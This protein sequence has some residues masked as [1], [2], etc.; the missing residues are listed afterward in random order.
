MSPIVVAMLAASASTII[1]YVRNRPNNSSLPWLDSF[2]LHASLTWPVLFKT[3]LGVLLFS[4]ATPQP[5]TQLLIAY[6]PGILAGG[7]LLAFRL[8]RGARQ[9]SPAGC[10]IFIVTVLGVPFT[11]LADATPLVFLAAL[12]YLPFC[13]RS[14]YPVEATAWSNSARAALAISVSAFAFAAL[15]RP[16]IAMEAC[17]VDKCSIF[18]IVLTSPLTGNGNYFGVATVIFCS[19]AVVG[20]KPLASILTLSAA[21]LVIESAGSRSAMI[22]LVAVAAFALSRIVSLRAGYLLG[23]WIILPLG[24]VATVTTA[25]AELPADFATG[26][27]ALWSVA[28]KLIAES[29]IWGWGPSYWTRQ[30]VTSSFNANYGTHNIWLE[31]GVAGGLIAVFALAFAAIAVLRVTNTHTRVVVVSLFIALAYLS[32]LESAVQVSRLGLIPAAGL[33]PVAIAAGSLP[34]Q[35]S[36][37]RGIHTVKDVHQSQDHALSNDRGERKK[38]VP[39]VR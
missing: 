29:P 14:P 8:V 27:S 5:E 22:A 36:V 15:I 24:V 3:T 10:A 11:L 12:A 2:W 30:Q 21:A 13:I 35:R 37:R 38:S 33:I 26:R 23:A 7:T 20:L 28:R 9:L 19:L 16:D 17:R 32:V 6:G 18:G 4:S 25:V 34:T 31:T 1:F 39:E